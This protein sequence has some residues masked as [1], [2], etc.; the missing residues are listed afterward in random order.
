VFFI[1]ASL[2]AVLAPASSQSAGPATITFGAAGDMGANAATSAS[3]SKLNSSDVDF[4]MAVGDL[5][6]KEVASPELWCDYV[7]SR[8]PSL[9]SS[10]PF[11]LLAGNHEEDNILQHAACLPDRLGSTPGPGSQY[12]VEYSFDYPSSSPL[13][14]VIMISPDLTINGTALSYAKNST[15]Y[16]WVA[17]QIDSGRSQGIPW[18]VVGM[19]KY[20]FIAES[21]SGCGIGADLMNM[22]VQKKVDLVIQ[23]HK[24]TYQRGKQLSLGAACASVAGSYDVDCVVDDGSD[25]VYSKGKGTVV[26]IIGC[27]GKG[28]SS[29]AG[30]YFV[31]AGKGDGFT[32]FTVTADRIDATFVN[33]TSSFADSYS[34]VPNQPPTITNP[35]NQTH[36]EG[37]S[38]NLPI[39]G[40]DPE[41]EAITWSAT[42][43]PPGLAINTATGVV[44]GSI[45]TAS[46]GTYATT[47]T[48]TDSGLRSSNVQFAWTVRDA[49]PA[50]PGTVS[51]GRHTTGLFL[52]WPDNAEGDLAGYNVFRAP[53]ATGTFTKLNPSL[54]DASEL[55][56][57]TAPV[58]ASSYYQVVAVDQ[59][60]NVSTPRLANARRSKIIFVSSSSARGSGLTLPVPK[61]AGVVPGDVLVTAIAV[62]ESVTIL[63]PSGWTSVTQV[64]RFTSLSHQIVFTH[65]IGA[66]DPESYAFGFLGRAAAVGT[67][68]AYRGAVEAPSK[69]GGQ[70]N[71]ASTS[72]TAPSVT[73]TLASSVQ[74]GFFGIDADTSITGPLGMMSRVAESLPSG[75]MPVTLAAADVVVDAVAQ[76]ARIAGAFTAAENAGQVVVLSP[77]P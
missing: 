55:W 27:F 75:S 32:K 33:A 1:A 21:S 23:G 73:P 15:H 14:R 30:G 57:N 8:L 16:N 6:Y 25:G 68:V 18:T 49:P 65:T 29:S 22:F 70:A 44:A 46:S 74:I 5:D 43:L 58:N 66:G 20:C 54:L 76:P 62:R 17:S 36:F 60:G 34:I 41:G 59:N 24:H 63:Q 10:F 42:G 39:A 51:I 12:S 52:D 67:T 45:S 7:N 40:V 50:M 19:H 3:L 38:V 35:G 9:G 53:T 48:A 4:F 69:V 47:V 31:K 72:I 56:D 26:L 28:G 61:P 64:S 37:Q 11:E 71:A 13:V 2:A 77:A